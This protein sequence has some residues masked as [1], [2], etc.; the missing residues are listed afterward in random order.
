VRTHQEIDE[1]SLALARAIADRIDADPDR[2]GLEHARRVCE[3]WSHEHAVSDLR[4]WSEILA[5]EWSEVR[6]V[7]LEDTE[8]GRQLRQSSPFCGILSPRERWAIYRRFRS[9]DAR[10]A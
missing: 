1:R 8:R 3:R 10:T 4:L 7:L 9:R 6:G 2:R 5:R